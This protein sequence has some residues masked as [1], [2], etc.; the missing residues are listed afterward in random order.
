[1]DAASSDQRPKGSP[2]LQAPGGNGGQHR[3]QHHQTEQR[4]NRV[5]SQMETQG[6]GCDQP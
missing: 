2:L 3:Q 6:V 5:L 4:Q 1:M